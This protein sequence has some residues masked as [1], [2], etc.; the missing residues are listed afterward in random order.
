MNQKKSAYQIVDLPKARRDMANFLD[1]F[2]WRH[3]MYGLL[4][5][6]VT[7]IRQFIKEYEARTGEKLSFTGY[8]AFCLAKAVDENKSVQA[9][10]KGSKQLVIYD[11][12]DVGLPIERVVGGTRAPTSHII[13]HANHK[14]SWRSTRKSAGYSH[15]QCH[16][17]KDLLHGLMFGMLLPRPLARIFIAI[18]QAANRHNPSISAGVAGTVGLTAVGMFNKDHGSGWGIVPPSHS[19]G[20]VVG[21]IALKPAVVG[22]RIEPR[23]ILHLTVGFD[24]DVVDGA[25]AARFAQRLVELI[26]GGYGL[27]GI[28]PVDY[29]QVGYVAH[30]GEEQLSHLKEK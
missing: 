22:D 12:V 5:V 13:R 20:L 15:S 18:V 3:I 26:E 2:W 21:G 23:E 1:L 4:E 10:L 19:L 14:T 11:D 7:V 9:M 29:Y 24:H 16:P 6:D 27:E 30:L 8:L 28:E 25:P 17:A